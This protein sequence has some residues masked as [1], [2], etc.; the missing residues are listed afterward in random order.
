MS[1]EEE[2]E[3][4]TQAPPKAK[5]EVCKFLI[6]VIFVV[7]SY[8]VQ[9]AHFVLMCNC[10]FRLQVRATKR[11]RKERKERQQKLMSVLQ[12]KMIV[13]LQRKMSAARVK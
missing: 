13:L 5:P 8:L 9:F 7:L 4:L 10:L 12:R 2:H 1:S 3:V 6:Y 11:K